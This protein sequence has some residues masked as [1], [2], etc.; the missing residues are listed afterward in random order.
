MSVSN[1]IETSW[2]EGLTRN[3][4]FSYK[5]KGRLP[6]CKICYKTHSQ[7]FFFKKF[8]SSMLH[9]THKQTAG[10]LILW[11]VKIKLLLLKLNAIT[12]VNKTNFLLEIPILHFICQS[13]LSHVILCF[14]TNLHNPMGRAVSVTGGWWF[15]QKVLYFAVKCWYNSKKFV[16]KQLSNVWSI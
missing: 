4:S 16:L 7:S 14:T 10:H 6:F 8:V 2:P 12:F 15:P 3:N 5:H 11:F 9:S 13:S 1:E